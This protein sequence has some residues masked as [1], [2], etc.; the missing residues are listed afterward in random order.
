MEEK[1]TEMNPD[2]IREQLLSPL[3]Y[4]ITEALGITDQY[5]LDRVREDLNSAK[6]TPGSIKEIPWGIIVYS[7]A[8]DGVEMAALLCNAS[9]K[10]IDF[11]YCD[12]GCNTWHPLSVGNVNDLIREY[13]HLL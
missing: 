5:F 10:Y 4:R 13:A 12:N 2:N 11:K 9:Q 7:K 8:P 1:D 6:F 3:Q